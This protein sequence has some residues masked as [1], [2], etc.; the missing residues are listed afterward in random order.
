MST[1]W[2]LW[3]FWAGGLALAAVA[4]GHW[5]LVG[6]LLAVSGRF[7]KLVDRV[8]F[9]PETEAAEA[10]DDE[11]L[12]AAL[13]AATL[14][15]FGLPGPPPGADEPAAAVA[16]APAPVAA[17]ALESVAVSASG[18][19]W[20]LHVVFLLAL[21][22]GGAASALLAGAIQPSFD[23][24][25]DAFHALM[26]RGTWVALGLGG[27]L[28]GFGTRMAGGCTSGHGLCG[29]S[30]LQRGSLAATAAFFGSGIATAFVLEALK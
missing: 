2:P 25:G 20:W 19:P 6:K 29:V 1:P 23:V 16:L 26:G 8:R 14:A 18:Q 5:L 28:V 3:P 30:R 9:G 11:A 10:V 27:F 22:A 12:V 21:G 13:Q 15:E 4:I 17:P 7:T 24:R